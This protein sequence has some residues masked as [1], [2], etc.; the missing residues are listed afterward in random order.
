MAGGTFRFKPF[1]DSNVDDGLRS[2]HAIV[3]QWVQEALATVGP[4]GWY[5]DVE[6]KSLPGGRAI[7]D[8]APDEARRLALAALVQVRHWDAETE[9]LRSQAAD[10][11]ERVNVH[12]RP[13][14]KDVWGPRRQ[15]EAVIAAL[16]RRSLPFDQTDLLAFLDWCNGCSRLSTH[17]APVGNIT[18]TIQRYMANHPL[19]PELSDALRK[20]ATRLRE[21]YDKDAKRHA[22]A[23]EQL[24]APASENLNVDTP[25]I[26]PSQ[27]RPVQPGP[28]GNPAILDV[29][30]KYLGVA[31][32][33][34]PAATREIGLDHFMLRDDSPL[35]AE[36]ELL[37]QLFPEVIGKVGYNDP[38]LKQTRVGKQVLSMEDAARGRMLLA[39]AERDVSG[40][41]A[42]IDLSDH[43]S[44]QSRSAVAGIV[45]QIARLSFTLDRDGT[46]DFLLFV[47]SR[48]TATNRSKYSDAIE[49]LLDQVEGLAIETPLTQGERFALYRLRAS[50]VVGPPLGTAS[51]DVSRLSALIGDGTTFFL[52]PGEAWTDRLNVDLTELPPDRRDAWIALL[53]HLLTANTARPSAKWLKGTSKVVAAIGEKAFTEALLKWF[54][55]VSKGRTLR[56]TPA[57]SHDSRTAADVMNE[58]NAVALRG[59]LWLAPTLKRKD[60]LLREVAAVAASAYRKVP[61][62]G[63]RAVKVGNAAVYALSEI[64]TAQ[65]VG[66]LAMLKV[67]VRFG[68]AQKEIEKAFNTSAEALGLPRDEI[69]E[70]GVPS[71]GMEEVGLRREEFADGF[72]AELRVDGRDVDL[73]WLRP[74]GKPQKSI[75]A[76]VKANQND[77][78]KELQGAAKDIAAMLPAQAER[79][80]QAFLQQK[81]W[82][83][84]GW[85]ERYLDHPLVGAIARRLIWTF[86]HAAGLQAGIWHEHRIVGMDD[87][88][89][90]MP[91]DAEV[92]LWHPIGRPMDE[93]IA[94][95]TWLE[96][97]QVRQ[98][99]KQAHR[100]V[101]LLTDAERRTGTYS[102]R[103]AA[104]ILRQHQFNALCAA[105]GWRNKLRLMVDDSY[106]PATRE[107][108]NWGLRAEFWIEA[109]GDAY[110][111]DT[112]DSGAYLRIATDQ[113]RFYRPA[114]AS[115]LA[116]AGGGGYVNLAANP[117]NDNVNAPLPLD[118]VPPL[119]L[120]EIL[121]DVDLFVGVASVGN[122]PTWQD[123]GPEGRYRTYWQ[124]F[125]FGELSETANTRRAVLER[126][127]P[128][129]TKIRDRCTLSDRFLVVLGELRTYKIHLGSGNILMEPNNQYLCIVPSRSS[130]N[131]VAADV[132]LPFEGD[133]TLSVILSKA[134]L[135]AA[136]R[137][138]TDATITRQITMRT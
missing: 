11:F 22:T 26:Q 41:L 127:L 29:L 20:F 42:R 37:S 63:P 67:R 28:A 32:N 49:R 107:L 48:V 47:A 88:P 130:S 90:E 60:E 131:G 81:R 57:F 97:N 102:N 125:S 137:K 121:R 8:S 50:L 62:V 56:R 13:G 46:F 123:G 111:Q 113:V 91:A 133:A 44:W 70:M 112:N 94:W 12:L 16:T 101:Y 24:C 72:A 84:A 30:K 35:A 10:E 76:G 61:G 65:A 108:P 103:F 39:A 18:R 117:G 114:A 78:L 69:E 122:D 77:E 40:L 2:E 19:G 59:L 33:A 1:A 124:N 74:D 75:P 135:L 34:A 45:P 100:E 83:L 4:D 27:C 136:D 87:K 132:F 95:R 134:F 55:L 51:P 99:F 21:A 23:I 109:I 14:W 73:V 104:H 80:D 118:Q 54:P 3:S 68:S 17:F 66:H 36:H 5:R 64:A 6:M 105:R 119:V 115:N 93:V 7:L 85:R 53:K 98:P 79:I 38:D 106:P 89:V 43:R 71:Y 58:E 52:A 120:S 31:A 138:I 96:R 126:L 110:G 129:L 128:R 92:E 25:P 9:R 116:H 82:N 15:A 86:R